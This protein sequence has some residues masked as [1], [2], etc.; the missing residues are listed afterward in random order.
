MT[1]TNGTVL[2]HIEM[3][4]CYALQLHLD[5]YKSY[6]YLNCCYVLF[7]SLISS[8][9]LPSELSVD[10]YYYCHLLTCIIIASK[11]VIGR[12]YNW[13]H[14]VGTDLREKKRVQ[15]YKNHDAH[16]QFHYMPFSLIRSKTI[17]LNIHICFFTCYRYDVHNKL[18]Y[19]LLKQYFLVANSL[20]ITLRYI[21]TW[22]NGTS[23]VQNMLKYSWLMFAWFVCTSDIYPAAL[24]RAMRLTYFSWCH[25]WWVLSWS[26]LIFIANRDC[27]SLLICIK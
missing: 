2:L 13:L 9:V 25:S 24:E 6:W 26:D 8:D 16:I 21:M 3:L 22:W 23:K 10:L 11:T 4:N 1:S 18:L 7:P 19:L 14:S 5:W 27:S 20:L 17:T 12:V 15:V